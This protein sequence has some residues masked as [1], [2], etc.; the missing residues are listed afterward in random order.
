MPVPGLDRPPLPSP[1]I[2]SQQGNPPPPSPA[3]GIGNLAAKR[4]GPGGP[5]QGA[6]DPNGAIVAQVEAIKKVLESMANTE[7]MMA[8]FAARATAILDSGVAAV[9]SA[10]KTPE[11]T[12]GDIGP[13]A[14]NAGPPPAP[15]GPGQGP[16]MA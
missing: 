4:P 14:G 7:P 8:P 5:A 9:R 10:P 11:G 6:P 12:G 16:P 13:T 15:G 1:D 3:A 2:Q